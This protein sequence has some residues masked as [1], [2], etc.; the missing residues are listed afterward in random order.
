[1]TKHTVTYKTVDGIDLLADLYLP[2]VAGPRPVVV[3]LHG[4]ALIMGSREYIWEGHREAFLRAGYA[5][6]SVD[7][8]LAPETKLPEIAADVFDA[9]RWVRGT[10]PARYPLDPTRIAVAGQSAG[11][12]LSLLVGTT[13]RPPVQAVVSFYGYGDIIGDWYRLPDPFYLQ[14]PPV[15]EE[16]ARASVGTAPVSQGGEER[17]KFYLY[18]RQQGRWLQEVVG[19]D[20]ATQAAAFAPYYPVQNV[21]PDGP[22]TLLLHG[23]KDTDVPYEQ[24][25]MMAVALARAG[26]AHGLITVPGG[27]HGFEAEDGPAVEEALTRVPP[28]LKQYLG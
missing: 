9:F 5:I 21:A 2:E 19:L 10:A 20:P 18:C 27:G 17:D 12:Y 3:W 28:F 23:D 22:P 8:R 6:V 4:G 13:L 11:G 16:E 24:S 26:V 25:V 7:Y 1:M 15:S 14:E